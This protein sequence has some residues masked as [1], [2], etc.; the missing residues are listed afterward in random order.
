MRVGSSRKPMRT[1]I[2]CNHALS[3]WNERES[4]WCFDDSGQVLEQG[5]EQSPGCRLGSLTTPVNPMLL[6]AAIAKAEV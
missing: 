1:C 6:F 4:S 5:K 3:G 2:G